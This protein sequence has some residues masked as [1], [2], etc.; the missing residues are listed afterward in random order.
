MRSSYTVVVGIWLGCVFFSDPLP[1][2]L[3]K[4]DQSV[5][6]QEFWPLNT[7]D[8]KNRAPPGM[9]KSCLNPCKPVG[10]N[11][12][13][14]NWL[15]GISEPST[16]LVEMIYTWNLTFCPI[17]WGENHPL[18]DSKAPNFSPFK[19]QPSR[20]SSSGV[21]GLDPN[22]HGKVWRSWVLKIWIYNT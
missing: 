1:P 14:L 4:Y 6:N 21:P 22:N 13:F 3:K 5:G 17:F 12:R 19:K 20:G 7:V 2:V 16:A 11:Y 18:K 15:G 8:G 10:H 9:S